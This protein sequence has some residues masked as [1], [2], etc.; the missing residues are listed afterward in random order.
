MNLKTLQKCNFM[1]I[2][3]GE[4]FR[5]YYE[6]TMNFFDELQVEKAWLF[7]NKIIVRKALQ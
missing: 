3:I 1:Y 6:N 5:I 7:L 2:Y 4:L